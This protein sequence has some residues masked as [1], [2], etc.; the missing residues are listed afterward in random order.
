M[1][2]IILGCG[3]AQG[4]PVWGLSWEK[5]W[6]AC[7]PQNPKNKRTRASIVVKDKTTSLLIDTSPDL[8]EQALRQGIRHVDAVLYTHAHADH[9][10]G[11]N[12]LEFF[13][14]SLDQIFPAF[15]SEETHR[16]L[17]ERFRYAFF[18]R[19]GS[20]AHHMP[21]LSPHVIKGP[22]SVGDFHIVPFEQ[23]HGNSTT[24]GFRIGGFAYS[25]DVVGLDEKAFETLDGV[26]TWLVDCLRYEPNFS[27]AHL[28]RVLEWINRVHPRRS[29]LTHLNF[30]LDY[31]VLSQRL[32][33]SVEVAYDGMVFEV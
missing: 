6:G 33:P 29:I 8:K 11:I 24:L 12:E 21:F 27:H 5:G 15:A 26:D 25:T 4:V 22:F 7:N 17:S 2:V 3:A 16:D 9:A 1:D 18:K 28:D 14:R 10:H 19:P 20:P 13:A 32:P 30:E 31:D 23:N